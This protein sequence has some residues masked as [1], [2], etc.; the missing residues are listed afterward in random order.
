VLLDLPHTAHFLTQL[1]EAHGTMPRIAFRT[2]SYETVRSAVAEGFGASILNMR[3]TCPTGADSP[4]ILRR[5]ILGEVPVATL[6]V[7]DNYRDLKPRFVQAFIAI[8]RQHF[9]ALGPTGYAVGATPP[10]PPRPS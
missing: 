5:P 6:V 7:A 8:L 3:P 4:Y 9:D 2:R 1:F 10:M